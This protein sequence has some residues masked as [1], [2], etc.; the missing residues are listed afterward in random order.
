[1]NTN[2]SCMTARSFS[3][4]TVR[5]D[6]FLPDL[7]FRK[8]SNY[9]LR[10]CFSALLFLLF[11]EVATAQTTVSFTQPGTT[12]YVIPQGVTSITVQ[13]YGGGG[14]GGSNNGAH[15]DSSGSGGG[16]GAY[17]STTLSV[18]AGATYYVTV[19]A[20][21]VAATGL[22]GS[23]G[24]SWINTSNT[25]SGAPVLAAAGSGGR[26]STTVAG[27][28]ALASACTPTAGASS[29]ANGGIGCVST[30]IGYGG[31]GGGGS[32]APVAL[33]GDGPGFAGQPGYG[34]PGGYGANDIEYGG[35]GGFETGGELSNILPG[36]GGGGSSNAAYL[37]GN[38]AGGKVTISFATP[39]CTAPTGVGGTLTLTATAGQITGTFTAPSPAPT[40]YLVIRTT[41]ATTP[42]APGNGITYAVQTNALG[43]F[44]VSDTT[45]TGFTD[46]G[47]ASNTKYWYWIYSQ[48][49]T[50]C[51]G[52]PLYATSSL[53]NS[54]T[55]PTCSAR[56]LTWAGLGS[57]LAHSTS[58]VWGTAANWS[59]TSATY[60][61][62]ATPPDGCA[63]VT[64]PISSSFAYTAT[65][66]ALPLTANTTIASLTIT[67]ATDNGFMVDAG[68]FNLDI[69]GNFSISSAGTSGFSTG[70]TGNGGNISIGGTATIGDASDRGLSYIGPDETAIQSNELGIPETY[71]FGGNVTFNVN[72]SVNYDF[73][74]AIFNSTSAQ[75]VS[76]FNSNSYFT[77]ITIGSALTL[78]G[79]TAGD[80]IGLFPAQ[81]QASSSNLTIAPGAS[82]TLPSGFGLNVEGG[83]TLTLGKGSTLFV[84]GATNPAPYGAVAG[85]NFPGFYINNLTA[86]T[87]SYGAAASQTVYNPGIRGFAAPYGNLI[88]ANSG[89]AVATASSG[90][91]QF[92]NTVGLTIAGNLT[93][94]S[95]ASF[96]GGSY[97]HSI[98]G[99]WAN[100]GT[101][102]AGTST[103]T[104]NGASQQTLAGVT[105]LY[106]SIFYDLI[107]NNT[108]TG[109]TGGLSLINN[110]TVTNVLTLTS[111][112]ISTGSSTLLVSNTAA[113]AV[114]GGSTASFVNGPLNWALPANLTKGTNI[115]TFPVGAGST[116]LPYSADSLTTG[117]TGPTLQVQAFAASSGGTGDGTTLASNGNLS[118][119]EY[120]N[121]TLL[122]G[123][124]TNASIS[125]TRQT[126][127]SPFNIIAKSSSKTGA[128]TSIGGTASGTSIG[129]SKNTGGSTQ[130]FYVMAEA[131]AIS[132]SSA[133]SPTSETATYGT[134][135]AYMTLSVSGA[136][137][138]SGITVTPP[139]GFV[140]CLTSGGT[141]SSS[142]VV[143]AAGTIASTPVY[144]E[145]S[146]ADAAGTYS[147][148]ITLSATSATNVTTAISTSTVN[149]ATLTINPTASQTKAYGTNDPSDGFTY[150]YTGL[151]AGGNISGML[152]RA[153]G[154]NVHSYAYNIGSLTVSNAVN[155]TINLT[156]GTFAILPTS[157]I[158]TRGL[159][160]SKTYGAN[161]PSG[162][163]TYTSSGL[164]SGVTPTYWNSSGS[165]VAD[166]S[167]I[168]DVVNGKMGR[169]AGENAATYFYNIGSV[170]AGDPSNYT[171]TFTVGTFAILPASLTIFPTA[172]QSKVYGTN[173]PSGGFTYSSSGLVSGVTPTYWN[174]S[175]NLVGDGT[176][177]DVLSGNL[178]RAAGE[179]VNTYSYNL[180]NLAASTP[181]NYTTSLTAGTFAITPA[182]LTFIPTA[183]RSKVYGTNDPSGGFP[184]NRTGLV[185]GVTPTYWNSSGSLVADGSAINDAES[186]NLGRAAGE[187]VGTYAYNLGS[188]SASDPSNYT[189]SITAATFAITPATLTITPT[190]GQS[191]VYGTND[192]SGGFTYGS[193]GL[194]TGVTP[195][196]WN[197][198]GSLVAES[199]AINDVLSGRLGRTAGEN[200]GTYA[201][202]LGSLATGDP[203]DYTTG[204]T[205]GSFA[206]TAA[207]LTIT[208]NNIIKCNGATYNFTG[209]EFTTA[210]LANG[211]GVSS[212]S[213]SSTGASS[214]ATPGSYPITITPGSAT[215]TGLNNYT[216]NY[217]NGTLKVEA[218]VLAMTQVNPD[219]Y[220]DPGSLSGS[221]TGGTVP[222]MYTVN[223]GLTYNTGAIVYGPSAT[224]L[225]SPVAPG[226]YTY[227]VT[228]SAGCMAIAAR[229]SVN[230]LTQ[231]AVL[232]GAAPAPP[233]TQICYGSTKSI[234]TIPIGG[235]TPYTYSLNTNGVS[236]P[237]VASANRYFSVPAGTYYITVKDNIGCSYTSNT[238]SI[239]QP[240]AAVSFTTSIGG[241]A[242]N[243]LAGIIVT[244][245]GGY[246]G[247]TYSDDG[248]TT[249]QPVNMFSRL[250]YGS[251]TV[252]VKDQNGCAAT[253]AV[254]KFSPLT[255]SPITASKNPICP[256]SG[257]TIYTVPNGGTAPYSY[258]LD[259]LLY[260]PANGRYFYVP[261][262]QH[263]ITV[264]DNVSCTY[265]PLS[266]T[267]DTSS[268]SCAPTLAGG[269]IEELQKLSPSGAMF[270]AHVMP[271]PAQTTFHLQLESNSREEVELVVMNMLGV[272]VYEGR[273]GID[274]TFEFG[275]PFTSGIYILQIRQGN[276]VHTVKLVKGN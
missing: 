176:I 42:T 126:A 114:S 67:S 171:T 50:E 74:L 276:T 156:A 266:I 149:K 241:Q 5:T 268:A 53:S 22:G 193:A 35:N 144:I 234:T 18:T 145:L 215:G 73:A 61:A 244:A 157:L 109:S 235:A 182:S 83:N 111:G 251:Y 150:S 69:L 6:R 161:D 263:T 139:T 92:D 123:S 217:A 59:T 2:P 220:G 54:A 24:S 166:G 155:Y 64:I 127:V 188:K 255:S 258:S 206:I 138:L 270:Q 39:V 79:G 45:M 49:S 120:W 165:L 8:T 40:N 203:S 259:G 186:G 242:C 88:I 204:F 210:G 172:G 28:G 223:T 197:S 177:N 225:Y 13:A 162:G 106:T 174:G 142:V 26:V 75:S 143:G 199:S 84:N 99:N 113:T 200:V 236:G 87:V 12:T 264:K 170:V 267:I 187:N 173:D 98:A 221:V 33:N 125:L 198:S 175:G 44:I 9:I 260:V 135:S 185:S 227:S 118:T 81:G 96:A 252:A 246:G 130:Q 250:S 56:S 15:G 232:L 216:I 58:L 36:G 90:E 240:A 192:P 262:G 32:S 195:T 158:I 121:S 97:L 38:G 274:D 141:Y 265:G 247:Y 153:A 43:G 104:F 7:S 222:Y 261:G 180:G 80:C 132:I 179:N 181:S 1:M 178:W 243:T 163:F 52:G 116:Y 205:A 228:D 48:N 214:S 218:L 37:G 51:S 16:G 275:G 95:G 254:V 117:A 209:T 100:N 151:V 20:G 29:G 271:N 231:T 65:D 3:I 237:F 108:A 226:Y 128:Y 233:V 70:L 256:G 41:S 154:E 34:G 17:T 21:G 134:A 238:V 213:L 169:A 107:M 122:S 101:F 129:M 23:G 140:V 60:T 89:G 66:Y 103:V 164:V 207:S 191:K 77:N 27:L 167:A 85:S 219:C 19:G 201:Y 102:T 115:Y 208:A 14:A 272:K 82:L 160:Q 112:E 10:G 249:Y 269:G 110:A 31:G 93:I 131:P 148:N 94:N 202:N 25:A 224:S 71:I 248:G 119:S 105:S 46:D 239:A 273:G 30:F 194:I 183:G 253:P 245:A 11:S 124:Y 136:A 168:N 196:Y 229:L 78:S 4:A 146:A 91:D 86:G 212:I 55:T 190:T 147:G 257:T 133:L 68:T 184:Y 63:T 189:T 211:D 57:N 137:M 47:L 152:G 62:A 230:P 72:G 159:G 76:T